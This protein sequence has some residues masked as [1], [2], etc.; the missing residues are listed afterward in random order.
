PT[1]TLEESAG[2]LTS[3]GHL[4]A[5]VDRERK[6]IDALAGRSRN[7]R[8]EHNRLTVTHQGRSRRLPGK[9]ADLDG[10]HVSA[11]FPLNLEYHLRLPLLSL[12]TDSPPSPPSPI[13][14]EPSRLVSKP[15]RRKWPTRHNLECEIHAPTLPNSPTPG[16]LFAADTHLAGFHHS[17]PPP[18]GLRQP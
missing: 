7:H 14:Q 15:T 5:I 3:R 10:Q 9:L 2:E 18:A 12:A 11:D 8:T 4:L 16:R 17:R 13:T 6:E 1:F